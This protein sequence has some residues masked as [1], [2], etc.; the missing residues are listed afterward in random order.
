M[1]PSR[2][3]INYNITQF[4]TNVVSFVLN[5]SKR[6][7]YDDY[8]PF[9]R[10]NRRIINYESLFT[11]LNGSWI[12]PFLT[13]IPPSASVKGKEMEPPGCW[14]LHSDCQFARRTSSGWTFAVSTQ[15]VSIPYKLDSRPRTHSSRQWATVAVRRWTFS[16]LSPLW[17]VVHSYSVS[18]LFIRAVKWSSILELAIV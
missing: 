18:N 17:V 13:Q 2:E 3:H 8:P 4:L 14:L 15:W 5:S 1:F 16:G 7:L 6:A 9:P 11:R 12:L 10:Y